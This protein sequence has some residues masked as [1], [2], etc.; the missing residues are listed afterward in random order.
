MTKNNLKE[1]RIGYDEK[2]K[3]VVGLGFGDNAQE[4][5]VRKRWRGP[6]EKGKRGKTRE[7]E[8]IHG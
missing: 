7:W 3:M 4:T 1:Q 5:R 2:G 8:S 6:T